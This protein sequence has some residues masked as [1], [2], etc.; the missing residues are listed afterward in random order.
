MTPG[1]D[2]PQ[3]PHAKRRDGAGPGPGA[4]ATG[5]RQR[6]NYRTMDLEHDQGLQVV[7][8]SSFKGIYA[9]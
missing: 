6:Y 7:L 4:Y 5:E 9:V 3:L 1:E 2:H 8:G